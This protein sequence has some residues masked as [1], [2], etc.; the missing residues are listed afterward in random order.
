MRLGPEHPLIPF[1]ARLYA[2]KG[3]GLHDALRLRV[4]HVDHLHTE[5]DVVGMRKW[6][7]VDARRPRSEIFVLNHSVIVRHHDI[8]SCVP[9]RMRTDPSAP[10]EDL[11]DDQRHNDQRQSR[12]VSAFGAG[13]AVSDEDAVHG[14]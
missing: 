4:R 11:D 7:V 10:L 13:A 8:E 5:P 2:I 12:W 1:R 6:V 14:E 9:F 3:I